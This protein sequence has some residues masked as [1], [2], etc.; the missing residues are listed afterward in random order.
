MSQYQGWLAATKDVVTTD[1]RSLWE[2]SVTDLDGFWSSV[3]EYFDV[4][5]LAPATTAD[6]TMPGAH[7]FPGA[8]LNWAENLLRHTDAI[9]PAIVA[10]DESGTRTEIG[11]DE[12]VSQVANLSARFRALGV[13][14]GDRIAAVL[15]NIAPTVVAVLAAA[16]V[17]AVWSCCAPDFGTK[18]LLDRFAQIEPTVLIGVDG[19]RFNHKT[20]DRRSQLDELRSQLPTVKHTIMVRNLGPAGPLPDGVLDYAELVTGEA[21]PRYEQVRF[22]HPLWILYSSGT[23]GLPE[24]IVHSHGGITI[25]AP[26]IEC[27]SPPAP[28]GWCGTCSSTPWSPVP[29]SSPTT[30]APPPT[31]PTPCSASAAPKKSPDSALAP[32]TSPC[33][34]RPAPPPARTSI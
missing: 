5:A 3:W 24:G 7:W 32:P 23:T 11:R 4:L 6:R 21:P 12:L 29:R 18:G 22:D 2:W 26:M 14:P 10:L 16:S 1:Y 17:G 30:A 25:S 27:S 28:P 34:R 13:R 31:V 33:A 20:I 19:Y 15:S 8:R 9:G